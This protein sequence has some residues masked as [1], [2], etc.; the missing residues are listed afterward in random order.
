MNENINEKKIET[1]TAEYYEE[2][3]LESKASA[4]AAAT[5]AV[6]DDE[7][8]TDE[9]YFNNTTAISQFSLEDSLPPPPPPVPPRPHSISCQQKVNETNT[10]L[11]YCKI[12]NIE[13]KIQQK[14]F[15]IKN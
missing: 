9:F 7:Q 4:V 6:G 11:K 1:I 13:K 12:S 2:A 3:D 14:S 8:S 10:K 15:A 5:K